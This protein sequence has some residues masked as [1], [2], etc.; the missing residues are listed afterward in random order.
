MD[1][2]RVIEGTLHVDDAMSEIKRTFT[3]GIEVERKQVGSLDA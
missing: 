2:A 3:Q 1:T